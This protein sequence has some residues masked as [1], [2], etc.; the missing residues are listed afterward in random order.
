MYSI[1]NGIRHWSSALMLNSESSYG[2]KNLLP[3]AS[4]RAN[5]ERRLSVSHGT[6]TYNLTHGDMSF[7]K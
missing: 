2:L 5:R 1:G 7:E 4:L 6:S 3:K